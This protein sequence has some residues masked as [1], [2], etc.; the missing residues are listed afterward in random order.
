MDSFSIAPTAPIR[1]ESTSP[2]TDS[3]P[4]KRG[5]SAPRFGREL[6][7]R[8]R[9]A[10]NDDVLRRA[11]R[12]L[13]VKAAV[14]VM[15]YAASFVFLLLAQGW[16][17]G[18]LACISF[19][20]AMTAVG[21]N[22]Q[23]DANHNAFF[24]TRQTGRLSLA[25]RI[26]GLSMHT[27]GGS[28]KRW[29][30][31]HVYRHHAAP[32]VVGKDDDVE[33]EPLARLA[34]A[35]RRRWW[36]A[37]QHYYVWILYAFTAGAIIVGDIVGAVADSVS[38]DKARKSPTVADY[39]IMLV[40][41][42]LFVGTFVVVPLLMHPWWVVLIGALGVLGV[43]GWVLGMVFQLAHVVEEADFSD[44]ESRDKTRWHEWQIRATVDF[45]HGRGLVPHVVTWFAGG[46]NFQTIHHL[47][48]E[49]PHTVYP[50]VAPVV[51]QTCEDYGIRYR[52]QP[53]LRAAV[54]S[55]YRH[56]RSLAAPVAG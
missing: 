55:H 19:A 4:A 34:P 30:D 32:N 51:A 39:T 1:R 31:G 24:R 3:P 48:P 27:I 28:S 26:A 41:K 16:I 9:E 44:I 54:A 22:I 29:I 49:L 40:S 14:V 20:L 37:F 38:S 25:N 42:A 5:K 36:H 46:L 8:V 12:S 43:S 15:W 18:T 6:S 2:T 7:Q 23:H 53:S 17:L 11:Y 21:F 13:H 52:V 47:F 45:C 50:K 56:V 35:Q 33:L 10:A